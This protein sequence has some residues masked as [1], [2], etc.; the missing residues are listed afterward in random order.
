MEEDGNMSDNVKNPNHYTVGGIETIKYIQAKLTPD[1]FKGYCIGN[2]I[3]YLSRAG[4]KNGLEDYKK[5]AV[6]LGWLIEEESK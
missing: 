4:Y 5:A 6:Y 3:K 2:C 1:Q